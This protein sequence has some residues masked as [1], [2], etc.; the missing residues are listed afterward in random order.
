MRGLPEL[1]KHVGRGA[2]LARELPEDEAEAMMRALAGGDADPVQIG[3]FLIAMRMKGE[4]AGEL[5]GF[6][7]ALREFARLDRPPA[8][9][10][11]DLHGDGRAGRPNVALA[12]ACVVASFG[13][14]VLVRTWF[15]SRHARNDLGATFA[16]LGLAPGGSGPVAVVDLEAYGPRV[17]A[18]LALREKIGVRTCVQTA[19]KL[20]D[21][22][23]ARRMAA[24]IFHS[25]YHEPVAGALVRLGVTRAAVVQAPGGTPEVAPDKPTRVSF[26]DGAEVRGPQALPPRAA[27]A[28]EETEDAAAQLEAVLGGRGAPGVTAMTVATAALWR[29]AAGQTDGP[30][31]YEACLAALTDGRA[32]AV[33]AASRTC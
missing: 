25:P 3:A 22:T 28:P 17:A 13:A 30:D 8:D 12:A 27:V 1:I 11:V 20:L 14:R 26:V 32:A 23:G 4:T 16:Q 9:L 33:L 6:V 10:D 15:G 24:G 2:R 5:A 21:P 18:L 19:V 31:G 29:W 7:R